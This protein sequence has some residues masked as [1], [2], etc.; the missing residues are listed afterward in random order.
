MTDEREQQLKSALLLELEEKSRK[1]RVAQG[2]IRDWGTRSFG[3]ERASRLCCPLKEEDHDTIAKLGELPA[4]IA[5][6]QN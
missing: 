1:L 3:W 5:E 2:P 6:Y 4:A